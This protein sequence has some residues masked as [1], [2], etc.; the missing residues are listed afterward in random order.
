[1]F[2]SLLRSDI[3]L[4]M[5]YRLCNHLPRGLKVETV[6]SKK[7]HRLQ[8]EIAAIVFTRQPHFLSIVIP[9]S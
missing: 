4:I 3:P 5:E 8:C 1:M 2:L 9:I 7:S 6:N